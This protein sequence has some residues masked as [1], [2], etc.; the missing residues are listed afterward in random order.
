MNT[1]FTLRMKRLL[2]RLLPA[3][4]LV[5][6]AG[7]AVHETDTEF[8]T[9]GDF[10]GDGTADVVVFERG[11]GLFRIGYGLPGAGLAFGLTRTSG[12]TNATAL[13]CG[14]FEST[15]RDSLAAAQ[16]GN[17]AISILTGLSGQY[18][19]HSSSSAVPGPGALAGIRFDD[20]TGAVLE[21]L[22]AGFDN[23]PA[24]FAAAEI[25]N[26]GSFAYLPASRQGSAHPLRGANPLRHD[27]SSSE[28]WIGAMER[29]PAASTFHLY[30]TTAGM[31]TPR[32]SVSSLA[33]TALWTS[34]FFDS[35]NVTL[36]FYQRGSTDVRLHGYVP[37]TSSFTLPATFNLGVPLRSVVTLE[38]PGAPDRLLVLFEGASTAAIYDYTAAGG[39]TIFQ[40]L[41]LDSADGLPTGAVPLP[42]GTFTTFHGEGVSSS[43]QMRQFDG[44]SYELIHSGTL[45]STRGRTTGANLFYFSGEPFV[46]DAPAFL[47]AFHFPD[48]TS[49][50]VFTGSTSLNRESYLNDMSGLS[51]ATAQLH[52][53]A[54]AGA[55]HAVGN[56]YRAD[57]SLFSYASPL[58][59]AV[60]APVITPQPGAYS[61]AVSVTVT[62]AVAGHS[63]RVRVNDSPFA[64]YTG[65]VV[66]VSDANFEAYAV[67]PD[68]RLSPVRTASYTFSQPPE[69]QDAD[70]D[71][72][73][74]FVE[75]SRGLDIHGGA[76]SDGD[77]FSDFDELA[78]V[79]P[80]DPSN[81]ASMPAARLET[82]GRFFLS[83]TPATHDG[84]AAAEGTVVN[85]HDVSG[86]LLG[87]GTTNA[88][89]VARFEVAPVTSARKFVIATTELIFTESPAAPES[90]V[91]RQL[92]AVVPVPEASAAGFSFDYD[93]MNPATQADA[94]IA[95]AQAAFSSRAPAEV[96]T[97]LSLDTTL[98]F[99]L[100]ERAIGM[101]LEFRG[102][103]SSIERPDF[104]NAYGRQMFPF[105]SRLVTDADVA[106]VEFP[107]EATPPY[108]TPVVRLDALLGPLFAEVV[109]PPPGSPLET[110]K[111]LNAELYSV[112]AAQHF[113][114]EGSLAPPIDALRLFLTFFHQLPMAYNERVSFGFEELFP[115]GS[116]MDTWL[117]ALVSRPIVSFDAVLAVQ[118]H[119]GCTVVT[120]GGQDWCLVDRNGTPFQFPDTFALPP[121]TT[122]AVTGFNDLPAMNGL[123][124][125]EVIS[126][127][128]SLIPEASPSDT[129]G[130]LLSDDWE[131]LF[132]GHLGNDPFASL[133]GSGYSLLQQSLYGTDPTSDDSLP[134]ESI[135]TF[136]FADIVPGPSRDPV[137]GEYTL[138]FQWPT[139]YLDHFDFVIRESPDLI[140]FEPRFAVI[141]HLGGG[142][143]RA[144]IP[145]TAGTQQFYRVAVRL[146]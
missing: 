8:F 15:S 16:P 68:G 107:A 22:F 30:D 92:A 69:L 53:S 126:A 93:E 83:A 45:P 6:L 123:P 79:P 11:T 72:V 115:L 14:Q 17:N 67:A 127:L 49:D 24:G 58:G 20:A 13:A 133:D 5:A 34:A 140:S 26:T 91:G 129:D 56:Q 48:W 102:I 124:V 146:R 131:R 12:V 141:T 119:P 104:L 38:R 76:D 144:V 43:W 73:P 116:A 28:R 19:G 110:L 137:T 145:G 29:L 105:M 60:A 90:P 113:T 88:M 143:H 71:S 117:Q 7:N 41:E 87:S 85:V 47:G 97:P 9:G 27:S 96:S 39:L 52:S 106:R 36:V 132:F 1:S 95:A 122:V 100:V 74:D 51:G 64:T 21:D 77:G 54:P 101:A 32:G 61:T 103:G 109:A 138:Y 75:A 3:L 128:A 37:G 46:T 118:T 23:D 35:T 10:N 84:H 82:N 4:P 125:M 121:G 70:N 111:A 94:W 65:P 55:S 2:L 135:V 81:P 142:L 136:Q 40:T 112:S 25:E 44:S 139:A 62:P 59:A 50:V 99:A 114:L 89:G 86:T 18:P 78:S 57:V 98:H 42:G 80:S 108:F 66:L 33:Q 134:A 63:L 31:L 130:N 120:S